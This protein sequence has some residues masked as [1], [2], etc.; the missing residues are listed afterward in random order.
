M[1]PGDS[2]GRMLRL[3]DLKRCAGR[4]DTHDSAARFRKQSCQGSC[5]ATDVEHMI[6][7]QLGDDTEVHR[8]VIAVSLKGVIDQREATV[9][10]D[11]ITHPTTISTLKLSG[12]RLSGRHWCTLSCRDD[13]HVRAVACR[14]RPCLS[15]AGCVPRIATVEPACGSGLR[16]VASVVCIVQY[17]A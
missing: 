7:A 15:W 9:G 12:D 10:K 8:K 6:R 14:L 13:E 5:P 1:D 17:C 11:R 4:I 2:S 16:I 3:G